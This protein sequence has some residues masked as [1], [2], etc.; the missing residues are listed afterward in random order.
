MHSEK[1]YPYP[2]IVTGDS[3]DVMELTDGFD[4]P[5]TDNL[6]RQMYVPMDRHCEYCG[7]NHSRM[8]R[9]IELGHTKWSPKTIGFSSP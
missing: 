8:I 7:V 2:Q 9:R 6:N 3:W 5:T 1:A 4:E